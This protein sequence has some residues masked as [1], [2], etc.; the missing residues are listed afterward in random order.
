MRRTLTTSFVALVLA[1]G[2]TACG[3]E[4]ADQ[5]Q[6]EEQQQRIEEQQQ[7]IEEQQQRIQEQQQRIQELEQAPGP[8]TPVPPD[9]VAP[10]A[11]TPTQ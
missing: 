5:Q 11:T 4:G 2:A 9:A 10:G 3:E 7:R 8:V 6:A 1:F